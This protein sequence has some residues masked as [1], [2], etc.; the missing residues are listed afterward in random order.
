MEYCCYC[1]G[2]ENEHWHLCVENAGKVGVGEARFSV[3]RHRVRSRGHTSPRFRNQLRAL[4]VDG[5]GHVCIFTL[6]N[7][8]LF[9]FN[10]RSFDT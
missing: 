3:Y 1:G 6:F 8:I 7:E 9:I 4:M 10:S 2:S 5:F